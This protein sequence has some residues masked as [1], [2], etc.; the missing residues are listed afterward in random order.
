MDTS[1]HPRRESRRPGRVRSSAELVA[2][3][4][5]TVS[6][7]AEVLRLIGSDRELYALEVPC[8]SDDAHRGRLV[9]L[10]V[11]IDGSFLRQ[12]VASARAAGCRLDA[13]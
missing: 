13:Q 3:G 9:G 10:S 6:S 1:K 4:A 8:V 5:P 2:I 7:G 11:M 12:L